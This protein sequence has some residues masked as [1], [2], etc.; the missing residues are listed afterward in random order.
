MSKAKI[1]QILAAIGSR[2]SEDTTQVEAAEYNWRE[3]HYFSS[4]QMKKVDDFAKRAALTVADKFADVYH[5]EFSANVASVSQHFANE[6]LEQFFGSEPNNYYLAFKVTEDGPCGLIA[7]PPETALI[8]ATQLLGDSEPEK[9][10][11]KVLSPL[12][13]SLLLDIANLIVEA[14]SDSH[15][16]YDFQP[17]GEICRGYLPVEL[18]GTEEMCKVTFSIEKTQAEKTYKMGEAHYFIH[19]E[20]LTPLAGKTSQAA[21]IFSPEETSK[22]IANSLQQMPVTVTAQLASIMLTF[23]Q[24]MELQVDDIL[25]LDRRIDEPIE[26]V[27]EGQHLLRGQ[28]AKSAGMYAVVITED[29]RCNSPGF[30]TPQQAHQTA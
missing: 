25:L 4:A 5:G 1:Q 7:M 3:P 27:V 19:C 24:I 13:E 28:P 9:K 22:A 30:E 10:P 17:A 16:S 12:E 14:F 26:L 2:P 6:L 15:T 21:N 29:L 8:W 20:K 11:R 18:Q 23:E